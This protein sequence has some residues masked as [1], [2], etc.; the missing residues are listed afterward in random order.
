MAKKIKYH[1]DYHT[2]TFKT[3]KVSFKQK[4]L[5]LVSFL[6]SS[7]VLS[8]AILV[9]LY[10]FVDS[11]KERILK[12]E[13]DQYQ[14]QFKVMNERVSKLN[15][16]LKDM[17]NRD[18]NVYRMI[19]EAEP[20]PNSVRNA[21]Y[22]GVDRYEK[23]QG[24]SNSDLLVETT[25]KIDKLSRQL[26]VQSKSYDEIYDLVKNKTK[27]LASIPAILPVSMKKASIVSGFGY[28]IHPIYKTMSMH[29]GV[30]IA[31][32]KGT[33]VYATGDGIVEP[34]VASQESGYGIVVNIAHGYGYETK[35]AHLSKSVAVA[36][37]HVKRGDLI[38]YVGST[39]LS[40]APHLHYEVIK[41]GTKVNPVSYFYMDVTPD[42]YQRIME[43][44]SKVNQALS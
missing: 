13:I 31:A 27:M 22:G 7:L 33:P 2:L 5:K 34:S 39:G 38:G 29:P 15:V 23:L 37:K 18:D 42:E 9:I 12:R 24:F 20:I 40:T 19:F 17:E 30:D 35:Y 43:E 16:V 10:T 1:F 32:A 28:R 21:A 25:K 26:Y 3:V 4:F 44:S 6:T 41:S 14:Y 8:T 11:P 36:G